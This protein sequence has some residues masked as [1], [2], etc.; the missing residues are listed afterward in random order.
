MGTDLGAGADSASLTGDGTPRLARVIDRIE[1]WQSAA[2]FSDWE[3]AALADTVA[4]LPR[5][6]VASA[7]HQVT[8]AYAGPRRWSFACSSASICWAARS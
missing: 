1:Q 3:R 5:G 7:T 8:G 6:D 4:Y 2:L